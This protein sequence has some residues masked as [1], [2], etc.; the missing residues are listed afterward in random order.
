MRCPKCGHVISTHFHPI[1]HEQVEDDLE[2]LPE[3]LQDGLLEWWNQSRRSKHGGKAAWTRGAW[4]RSIKRVRSLHLSDP[5]RAEELVEAGIEAGWQALR[6]EY[7]PATNTATS[8][9]NFTPRDTRMSTAIE[10]W[11]SR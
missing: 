10:Q 1:D 9:T 11:N 8:T 7:V 3:E 4:L 6:I 2:D 5:T